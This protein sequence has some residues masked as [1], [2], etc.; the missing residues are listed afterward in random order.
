GRTPIMAAFW[1]GQEAVV[2][3]LL[4]YRP[5][6]NLNGPTGS[7][8]R[9]TAL[10]AAAGRGDVESVKLLIAAGAHD[11]NSNENSGNKTALHQ[12][13]C[14]GYSAIA[15]LLIEEAG[16]DVSA[17]TEDGYTCLHHVRDVETCRLLLRL[18]AGDEGRINGQTSRYGQTALHR[19]SDGEIARALLEAGADMGIRN[20]DGETAFFSAVQVWKSKVV[21]VMLTFGKVR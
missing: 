7:Y 10:S 2:E 1:T 5:F 6:I 3:T 17:I 20:A 13:L 16:S 11:I 21:K 18:G 4:A 8:E 12:A 19:T 14:H 15:R 9:N